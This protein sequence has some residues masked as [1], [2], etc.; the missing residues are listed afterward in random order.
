MKFFEKK[1]KKK[2]K[3]TA[4]DLKLTFCNFKSIM[5]FCLKTG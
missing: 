4:M 1:F 3:T 5:R 2:K